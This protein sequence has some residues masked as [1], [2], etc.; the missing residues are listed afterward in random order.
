MEKQ[1]ISKKSIEVSV[2]FIY[3]ILEHKLARGLSNLNIS[4]M[5]EK[6]PKVLEEYNRKY[7]H[8]LTG[9]IEDVV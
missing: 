3:W 2:G 9:W 4:E 6:L 8:G 1:K 5:A 7:P